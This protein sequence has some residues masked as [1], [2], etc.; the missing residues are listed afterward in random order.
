MRRLPVY[1][2]LD[3]S[4]SMTGQP[5]EQL[6]Q[7]L[8]ALINDLMTEPM[9]VETVYLSV[10]TFNSI[11]QQLIPLTE[12][13]QFK[14]PQIEASGTTALGAALRLLK[15]CLAKEILA[16]TTEQKADWK[17]LVFLMTDGLP[18]D[19]WEDIASELKQQPSVN[20][21]AFATGPDADIQN[22]KQI[23]DI[24]L[25]SE[26]LSSGTLKVFFQ[27]ISR[28]ILQTGK[29]VQVTS[30]GTPVDLPPPPPQIQI[31]P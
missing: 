14:E 28:S 23:T 20:L 6:R 26:E 29:S 9:A 5:I 12:I 15:N 11:A 2:L 25:K 17:P 31:V 24:V 21:I 13:M 18:T 27:W 8:R 4:A 7:G 19:L 1:L 10:I 30:S 22:L 16:N 3:C